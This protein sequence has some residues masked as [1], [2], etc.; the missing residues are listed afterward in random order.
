MRGWV[1][2]VGAVAMTALTAACI[3][4]EERIPTRSEKGYLRLLRVSRHKRGG[5]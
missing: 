3:G 4:A 5:R 2:A 1:A